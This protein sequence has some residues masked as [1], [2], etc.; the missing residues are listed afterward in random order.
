MRGTEM[1]TDFVLQSKVFFTFQ[2]TA[3]IRLLKEGGKVKS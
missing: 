1:Y 3:N 2:L